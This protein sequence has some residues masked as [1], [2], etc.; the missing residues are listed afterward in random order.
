MI[1]RLLRN[2]SGKHM[3]YPKY[4]TSLYEHTPSTNVKPP[5]YPKWDWEAWEEE[6]ASTSVKDIP[7]K[8]III[9]DIPPKVKDIPP[10]PAIHYVNTH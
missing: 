7:P 4:G 8:R 10:K 3:Y 1:S 6:Q 9:K 2:M 5:Q